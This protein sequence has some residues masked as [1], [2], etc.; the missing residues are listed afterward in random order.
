M[1]TLIVRKSAASNHSKKPKPLLCLN[2][3]CP[4]KMLAYHDPS[5]DT[6]ISCWLY[7]TSPYNPHEQSPYNRTK[8]R[9]FRWLNWLNLM[10]NHHSC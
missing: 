9:F 5:S 3:G 2:I 7:R 1:F 4:Q 10:K 6:P 8:I